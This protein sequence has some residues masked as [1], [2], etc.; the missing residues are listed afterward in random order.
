MKQAG[1][2]EVQ[3][4]DDPP[5]LTTPLARVLL[6]ILLHAAETERDARRPVIDAPDAL[7]S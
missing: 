3:V 1:A 2:P 6:R 5:E 7:A 4:P